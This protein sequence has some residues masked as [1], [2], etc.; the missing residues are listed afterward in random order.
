MMRDFE[1]HRHYKNNLQRIK[2][3]RIPVTEGRGGHL[4]PMTDTNEEVKTEM[5]RKS[6]VVVLDSKI[7]TEEH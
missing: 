4:Q 7:Q 6:E 1:N 5:T 3:R 2:K